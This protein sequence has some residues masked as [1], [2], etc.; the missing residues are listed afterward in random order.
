M[1][2]ADGALNDSFAAE[3]SNTQRN[4][5]MGSRRKYSTALSLWVQ[6]H[7]IDPATLESFLSTEDFPAQA[8]QRYHE[9]GDEIYYIRSYETVQGNTQVENVARAVGPTIDHPLRSRPVAQEAHPR[10]LNPRLAK[11]VRNFP[12]VFRSG[13]SVDALTFHRWHWSLPNSQ[14]DGPYRRSRSLNHLAE[15]PD[16]INSQT[17]TNLTA[18]DNICEF[19]QRHAHKDNDNEEKP[20]YHQNENTA[21]LNTGIR[22][23]VSPVQAPRTPSRRARVT[24]HGSYESSEHSS[25]R[26]F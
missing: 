11:S 19:Y 1:C 9:K 18:Y 22:E 8:R 24:L 15:V 12:G 4:V 3:L 6:A 23:R 13:S 14:L 10:S 20:M 21:E 16:I 5:A 17:F 2:L 26:M 25:N 7:S